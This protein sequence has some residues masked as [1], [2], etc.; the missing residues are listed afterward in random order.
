LFVK[1]AEHDLDRAVRGPVSVAVLVVDLD[2]FE[3][4]NHNLG[5]EAG[6][7]C[8]RSCE[9]LDA[10]AGPE[11]TVALLYGDE[12]AVLLADVP[13]K[14]AT[15]S[16][17]R[18]IGEALRDPVELDGGEVLI[19]ANIGLPAGAQIGGTKPRPQAQRGCRYPRG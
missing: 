1:L 2:D 10:F 19:S 6:I 17:A 13:N 4:T 18:R 7:G 3:G 5:R 9:R 16:V 8:S 15:I 14:S 11:N 12:F